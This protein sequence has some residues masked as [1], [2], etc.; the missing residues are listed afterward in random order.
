MKPLRRY[1]HQLA[2]WRPFCR[3]YRQQKKPIM[4]KVELVHVKST[5]QKGEK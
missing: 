4:L 5:Y 1:S 2:N 3:H